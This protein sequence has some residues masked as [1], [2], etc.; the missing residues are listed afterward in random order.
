[1]CVVRK[2]TRES[3]RTRLIATCSACPVL[4]GSSVHMLSVGR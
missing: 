4:L 1:M 3:S 2:G